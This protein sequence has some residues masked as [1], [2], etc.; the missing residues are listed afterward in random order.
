MEVDLTLIPAPLS[1]D[2]DPEPLEYPWT[3][4][5]SYFAAVLCLIQQQRREDA[6][7]MAQMFN[8]ELPFCASVV[9]PTM[10]QTPYGATNRSA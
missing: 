10:I 9:C 6:A 7:A 8:A 3:D 4:A 1:T 2:D 5:V